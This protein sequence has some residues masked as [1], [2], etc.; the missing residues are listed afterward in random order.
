V[1]TPIRALIFDMD[2]T[3]YRSDGLDRQYADAVDAYIAERL[4]V[5]KAEARELFNAKRVALAG[6]LGRT[7]TTTG[8]MQALGFDL[9]DWTAWRDGF[10]RPED[11]LGRDE[12]LR[13]VL[14]E[15]RKRCRLAVVT[16]NSSEMARRTLVAIGIEDLFEHVLTIQDLGLVKPHPDIYRGAA[17]RLGVPPGECM[18]VGDRPAVD[19]E[20]AAEAGMQT[21]LVTGP[22]DIAKLREAL[23][24]E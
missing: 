4:D 18:S 2:G 21:F 1:K 5:S 13:A 7:P 9:E 19:L 17:E 16:N 22:Q 23:H 12:G 3:L 20:P 14:T 24:A 8:T 15:L 10:V 11:F 6:Q